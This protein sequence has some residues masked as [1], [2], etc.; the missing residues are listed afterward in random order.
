[1]EKWE[2]GDGQMMEKWQE[3]EKKQKEEEEK[4]KKQK[5]KDEDEETMK[6]AV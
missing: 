1:M 5:D 6:K 4:K 3:M 2:E